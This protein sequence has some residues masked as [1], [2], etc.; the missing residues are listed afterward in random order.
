MASAFGQKVQAC[1]EKSSS[2]VTCPFESKDGNIE[3]SLFGFCFG[4]TCS[5]WTF[6]KAGS[7]PF[8]IAFLS[9]L[10]SGC[11]CTEV[12]GTGGGASDCAYNGNASMS[13]EAKMR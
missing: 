7:S 12:T 4:R 8:G 13:V 10:D 5:L 9:A 11:A 1:V 3:L 2:T 6:G